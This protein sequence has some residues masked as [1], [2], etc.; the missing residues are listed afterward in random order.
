MSFRRTS[1]AGLAAA[2]V[3]VSVLGG[4]IASASAATDSNNGDFGESPA[5]LAGPYWNAP[6]RATSNRASDPWPSATRVLDR[7]RAYGVKPILEAGYND[8][9]YESNAK[10]AGSGTTMQ[11]VMMHDTGTS[12]PASRLKVTHSLPWILRGVKSSAG[13]TVRAC[14]FYVDRAGGVHIV[15][16]R[17]TWHAGSGDSMFGVPADRMNGY[18]MGIEIES[19]GGGVKDLTSSQISSASKVAAAAL[20]AAGL[21][22]SRAINH[23]DYAGRKQGK[24]DTAWSAGWW[25]T[26]I[27]AVRTGTSAATVTQPVAVKVSSN[28]RHVSLSATRPGTTNTYVRRYQK[29]LRTLGHKRHVKVKRANPHGATGYYGTE[30]KR[31]TRAVLKDLTRKNRHWT[32]YWQKQSHTRPTT[33]LIRRLNLIPIK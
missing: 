11:A 8:P 27:D 3:A 20:D 24:V 15:Y 29:G 9:V 21:P 12:V 23:K 26:K 14:H 22:T 32:R 18:S 33:A 19:Q 17:R 7:L 25:R 28:P 31:L 1:T 5:D 6:D 30:T 10:L 13:K 16:L 2:L 4:T